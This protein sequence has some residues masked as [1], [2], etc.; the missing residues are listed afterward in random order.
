VPWEIHDCERR[1]FAV[2]RGQL[3]VA[4]A[5]MLDQI[6]KPLLTE[7]FESIKETVPPSKTRTHML[8]SGTLSE[9][10]YLAQSLPNL[11]VDGGR[12]ADLIILPGMNG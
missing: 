5:A 10:P 6:F 1:G 2:R 12:K 4:A 8:I 7:I 3:I 9:C 11:I